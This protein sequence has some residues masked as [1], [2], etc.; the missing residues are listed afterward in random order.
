MFSAIRAGARGYLVKGADGPE[1]QRAIAVVAD[2]AA[3]F[4]P[5]VAQRVLGSLTRPLSARD[6]ALFPNLSMRERQVLAL[7]AAGH[8]NATIAARLSLSPKT[9]RN[10]VSSI[11]TK[12]R[13]AGRAE[14]I[15]RARRAGLGRDQG[16]TG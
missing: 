6:E 16:D 15:V 1:V 4:G 8:G 11:V 5:A 3:I 14:A 9:V 13:V 10:N 2:G 7:I 12:L